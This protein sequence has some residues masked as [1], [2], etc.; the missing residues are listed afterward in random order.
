MTTK[1]QQTIDAI[2]YAMDRVSCH[3][4]STPE[5]Y[6]EVAYKVVKRLEIDPLLAALA[7]YKDMPTMRY[8]AINYYAR[9][10]L[11]EYALNTDVPK[12]NEAEK[13]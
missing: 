3:H 6:A 7:H 9:V 8:K 2:V 12:N 4:G 10:A 5:D 13:E 1:T 11:D